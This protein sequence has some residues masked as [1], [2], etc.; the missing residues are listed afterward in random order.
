MCGD[1]RHARELLMG[2]VRDICEHDGIKLDTTV[3]YHPTSN[4][5]AER[6]VGVLTNAARAMLYNPANTAT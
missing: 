4:G 3:S 6:T 2:E 5:V 1:D